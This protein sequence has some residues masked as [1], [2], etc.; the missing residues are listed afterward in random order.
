MVSL[1]GGLLT[2]TLGSAL[3]IWG[4]N[5]RVAME[6]D[7][8]RVRGRRAA[9]AGRG[10]GSQLKQGRAVARDPRATAARQIS[11]ASVRP[12]CRPCRMKCVAAAS[13]SVPKAA[14]RSA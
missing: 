5:V 4:A 10:A 2:F 3:V 9:A 6:R 12:S 13:M 11:G 14:F 8:G 1:I 7:D